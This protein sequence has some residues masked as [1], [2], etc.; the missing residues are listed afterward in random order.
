M[1]HRSSCLLGKKKCSL[2]CELP[3]PVPCFCLHPRLALRQHRREDSR[4]RHC[5]KPS[6]ASARKIVHV[7]LDIQCMQNSVAHSNG[8]G[9]TNLCIVYVSMPMPKL[10]TRRFAERWGMTIAGLSD[11]NKG[12]YSILAV[13]KDILQYRKARSLSRAPRQ[14]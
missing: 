7:W 1:G 8:V 6:Q 2:P 10:I 12:I 13:S 11:E 14:S 4:L 3:G 5:L 9:Q